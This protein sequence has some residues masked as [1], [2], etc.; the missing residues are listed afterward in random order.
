MNRQEIRALKYRQT[1]QDIKKITDLTRYNKK[2]AA[3]N[4]IQLLQLRRGLRLEIK[5]AEKKAG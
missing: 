2:I 5:K 3:M 1:Q 4:L